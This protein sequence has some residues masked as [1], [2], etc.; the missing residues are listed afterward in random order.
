[1]S[2]AIEKRLAL[3]TRSAG[4]YPPPG[5]RSR[6]LPAMKA[7]ATRKAG[8]THFSRLFEI[9]KRFGNLFSAITSW[10]NIILAS[11]LAS[12]GKPLTQERM[13]FDFNL[14]RELIGIKRA[15][16][17]G[18]YQPGGYRTFN[19]YDPKE[20]MISAAPFRDRVVHHCICNVI[21]PVFDCSFLS[22]NYANRK[23]RGLHKAL[24]AG[25]KIVNTSPFLLK[26]DIKKYFPSIDHRILK[27]IIAQRIKCR[28]TIELIYLIIDRSNAQEAVIAYFPGDNLFTPL[29][30]R[31]GLPIGNLTS[32]LFANIYLHSLD[33][34]I[35][36]TLK[37]KRYV[38][39]V[40]DMLIGGDSKEELHVIKH[41]ISRHLQGLRIRFHERKTVVFPAKRGLTFLG[42][43]LFP[44]RVLAGKRCG[45]RFIKRL[46]CLQN[47]YKMGKIDA[48]KIKQVVSSY[49]GHLSHGSTGK[50]RGKILFDHPFIK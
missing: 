37:I 48:K 20:R 32:Q 4:V 50:L 40:D 46:R 26:A 31:R 8:T 22:Q 29:E 41:E 27:E 12:R 30:R 45:K 38:R 34:F 43:R 18:T 24:R 33:C 16:E 15:L 25:S 1:M 6:L 35:V 23:G 49:N 10:E 17:C 3:F 42:F 19:I 36:R 39:Y 28:R 44:G 9:M 13:C 21:E 11:R 2:R 14:E 47:G 7:G 5:A